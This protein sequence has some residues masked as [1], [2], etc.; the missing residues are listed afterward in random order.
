M[1]RKNQDIGVLNDLT[2]LIQLTSHQGGSRTQ[3]AISCLDA[4]IQVEPPSPTLGE[5]GYFAFISD[6]GS[7]YP[8]ALLEK[9]IPLHRMLF[10]KTKEALEVWRAAVEAVQ[11]GLFSW[12]FLRPS[13][14]CSTAQLRKLQLLSE[15]NKTKVFVFPSQKL[16]HWMFKASLEVKP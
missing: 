6:E 1:S 2:G 4:A 7:L 9:K 8:P 11:T 16:P 10:V 15:K 5:T 3:F 14:P 13:R 12:V